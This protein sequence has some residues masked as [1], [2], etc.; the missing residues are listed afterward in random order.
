M[1]TNFYMKT[2]TATDES[3]ESL[4]SEWNSNYFP[5]MSSCIA[6][7]KRGHLTLTSPTSRSNG[8]FG[9]ACVRCFFMFLSAKQLSIV[10]FTSCQEDSTGST[11]VTFDEVWANL[12]AD[13]HNAKQKVETETCT[14]R[15]SRASRVSLMIWRSCA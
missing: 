11:A 4:S 2:A 5:Q 13:W 7:A 15:L 8:C 10:I 1:A 12:K 9:K 6:H 3:L 14:I